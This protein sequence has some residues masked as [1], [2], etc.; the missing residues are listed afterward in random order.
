Y[1][2]KRFQPSLLGKEFLKTLLLNAV[3]TEDAEQIRAETFSPGK[4]STR[5]Q[6]VNMEIHQRIE[7]LK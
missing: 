6:S 4:L 2:A 7:T 3:G 1:D 5:Y